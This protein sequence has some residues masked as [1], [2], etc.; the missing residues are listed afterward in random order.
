MAVLPIEVLT[1]RSDTMDAVMMVLVVLG[2]LFVVR[3]A[4]GGSLVWLLGAAAT[5]GLAFDVK[6]LESL[7]P[8]PGLA[9]FAYLALP[10]TRRRRLLLMSATVAVYVSVALSWLT[11]TLLFPAHDRPFAIGSTNGSAWN[12]AFVFNGYDRIAGKATGT[13]PITFGR[14][15][16]YPTATQSQRD[17]IPI[18][19]PSATR[20]LARIGPL[21]GERL[22]LELL[23]ALLL[24]APALIAVLGRGLPGRGLPG[25]ASDG[26]ARR[27]DAPNVR[28]QEAPGA[29]VP[30]PSTPSDVAHRRITRGAAAGL[31]VWLA[32][33]IVLFSAM[34]RLHPRYVEGFTPAVAAVLGIGVAWATG[35]AG[36][37]SAVAAGRRAA[38]RSSSTAPTFSMA[39]PPSGG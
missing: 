11:A 15:R 9:L 23:G 36:G 37:A 30:A 31:L 21:S 39:R 25:R 16:R 20:L 7:V 8:L 34:A 24:G 18:T 14:N 33:G 35:G 29:S 26:R 4:E 27:R 3:A 19:P 6:L 12:A 2:L 38:R 5:L 17:H 1:S 22:G 10:G 28:G 13:D 32:T